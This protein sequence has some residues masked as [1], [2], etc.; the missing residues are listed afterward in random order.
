ML[1]PR[2]TL[3]VALGFAITTTI[4]CGETEASYPTR[5]CAPVVWA[6]P[7]QAG[8]RVEVLGSWNGWASPGI[9][10][11]PFED[12]A[13]YQFARVDAPPGEHGYLIEESGVRRLD[14]YNPLST[15]R[16][17]E[18]VSLLV[19][20]DCSAPELRVDSVEASDDGAAL[21]R[22]TLLARPDG[23]ALDP[24]SVTAK[25]LDGT[26]LT[27]D[28]V[29]PDDGSL[30]V[31]ASGLPRGKHT[32]LIEA[33]DAGGARALETRAVAWVRPAMRDLEDGVLYQIMIDRFRGPGGAPL[34]PPATPTSR[35]GG[36]LDGVTAELER[37]TF[38]ALG[39]TALWLSPVYTNPVEPRDGLDGHMSEGYHGYWP[40]DSRGV[41]DR[42]GGPA[43]LRELVASAHR[44]GI[45]VL[46]DLVPNHVYEA[47]P[48]YTEHAPDGWFHEGPDKCVC[49]TPSCPWGAHIKSCWFT[50]YLPD[51]RWEHPDA[52]R[53]GIDDALWWSREFDTDG[54]RVDAVPMMPRTVTRRIAGA[55]RESVAPRGA[56]SVLGEVFTG[57]GDG[58]IDE[59]RYYLG[60]DGLD[61]AFDFP[62]MWAVREALASQS[63]GFERVE[64]TLVNEDKQLAGSGVVLSRI[65]DNHDTSRF[66]SEANGDAAGSAWSNPPVQPTDPAVYARHRMALALILTLPGLPTLYYGDEVALPGGGDPDSRRV[67]P[68]DEALSPEQAAS[69]ETARRLGVLRG[70]SLALRRGDRVPLVAT[71]RTY[72][73][74]RDAGD[75]LPV[76]AV[77]SRA[78]EQASIP[79]FETAVP[80]AV[81]VDVMTGEE[82]PLGVG[83]APHAIPIAPLSFRILIPES[84]PCL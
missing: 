13:S 22:A 46:L 72:A 30:V 28:S 45:R 48:R 38:D 3:V 41:D 8:A 50:S 54:V 76:L 80:A 19:S 75:G 18:E 64:Q 60:K 10:M 34:A 24:K 43:V 23:P 35:A 20:P 66:I 49:G 65:L 7:A 26:P 68:A 82:I 29:A 11:Q 15:Y 17:A 37:G 5:D 78:D 42:I 59:I 2:P 4:S 14:R 27:V 31:R 39:V 56:Q 69:R 40:L 12:D 84:S 16:G 81:Y 83:G 1:Y 21:V 63:A 55:L 74:A 61:S 53:A 71:S 33:A 79:I 62:L 32:I 47:N 9:V 36:T 6:R 77:F 57:P 51:V 52:M 25:L 58:A 67:M 70:C 44:R 73:F